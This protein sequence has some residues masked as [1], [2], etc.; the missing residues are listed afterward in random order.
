MHKKALFLFTLSLLLISCTK[1][2]IEKNL[3][4]KWELSVLSLDGVNQVNS[5]NT[6]TLNFHSVVDGKGELTLQH[7]PLPGPSS[8]YYVG[9]FTLNDD[10]TN[11]DAIMSLGGNEITLNGNLS[12]TNSDLSITGTW[13]DYIVTGSQSLHIEGSK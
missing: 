7:T 3:D 9:D 5:S 2:R 8:Y 10:Y 1:N 13:T 4:N 12:V 6:Y 11:I